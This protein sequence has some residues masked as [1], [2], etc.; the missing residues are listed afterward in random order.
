MARLWMPG[1]LRCSVVRVSARAGIMA[2]AA[3]GRSRGRLDIN[4]VRTVVLRWICRLG[5]R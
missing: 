4:R 5:R 1:G 2:A 3:M